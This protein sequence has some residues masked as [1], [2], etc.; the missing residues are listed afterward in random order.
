MI[1]KKV[2]S[3]PYSEYI[4]MQESFKIHNE[5]INGSVVFQSQIDWSLKFYSRDE[6]YKLI[7]EKYKEDVNTFLKEARQKYE[8]SCELYDTN[9]LLK[10]NIE[11]K[12]LLYTACVL[13][14]LW[15]TYIT[16]N[17]IFHFFK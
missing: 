9:K 3:I 6:G 5:L 12:R 16:L 8:L 10:K 4:D 13:F 14:C 17:S 15:S 2:I 1:N 11:Q 7:N